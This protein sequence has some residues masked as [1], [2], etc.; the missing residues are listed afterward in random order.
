MSSKRILTVG[1][2]LADVE[3][4]YGDFRSKMSLLDWDIILFK[5]QISEFV[6][7]HYTSYQ[8]RPCLSDTASFEAK[9]C[10]E[11][12]RREIRQA[13]ET[14]KTVLVYLPNS[15]VLIKYP[16]PAFLPPAARTALQ[17]AGDEV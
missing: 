16:L 4:T 11:H 5:P 7:N 14:G 12:W 13:V 17:L 15:T 6:E 9:E 10:C 8:G 2:E 1:L 3:A